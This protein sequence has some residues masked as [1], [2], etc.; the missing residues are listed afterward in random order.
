MLN[1]I[2]LLF[3]IPP[4]LLYDSDLIKTDSGHGIST[5]LGDFMEDTLGTT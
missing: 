5:W 1:H 3:L 4:S 2:P